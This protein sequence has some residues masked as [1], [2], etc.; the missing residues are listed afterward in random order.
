MAV[1]RLTEPLKREIL[2][3]IQIKFEAEISRVFA[4]LQK[5]EVIRQAYF[6]TYTEAERELV[7]RLNAGI[8]WNHKIHNF[9]VYFAPPAGVQQCVRLQSSKD[10][11]VPNRGYSGKMDV[12]LIPGSEAYAHMV[13]NHQRRVQLNQE[14]VTTQGAA[15]QMMD[16]LPTLKRLLEFWP[17]ALDFCPG[18]AV[19]RHHTVVERAAKGPYEA[20]VPDEFKVSIAKL[21]LIT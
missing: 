15:K 18:E 8:Q 7:A 6:D 14:R 21:R 4:E 19:K 17:S 1:V 5:D 11:F 3:N 2:G 13:E 16:G 9:D 12:L 20:E 10:Y